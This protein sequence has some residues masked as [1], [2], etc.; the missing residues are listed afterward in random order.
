MF[1]S[2]NVLLRMNVNLLGVVG[3]IIN[4]LIVMKAMF[5]LVNCHQNWDLIAVVLELLNAYVKQM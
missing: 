5:Y 1:Y 2:A 3:G 4:D